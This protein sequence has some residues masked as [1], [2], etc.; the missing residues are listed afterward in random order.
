MSATSR[1]FR[2]AANGI[3]YL[4]TH[5]Y[6]FF[7]STQ[8]CRLQDSETP[9]DQTSLGAMSFEKMHSFIAPG[10][11]QT[12]S[13]PGYR[14]TKH[15][16]PSKFTYADLETY[17][18]RQ[19]AMRLDGIAPDDS[20]RYHVEVYIYCPPCACQLATALD[21]C[22]HRD[23]KGFVDFCVRVDHRLVTTC[24]ASSSRIEGLVSVVDY[25][26]SIETGNPLTDW[27]A[28]RLRA[29][30]REWLERQIYEFTEADRFETLS[31]A[32]QLARITSLHIGESSTAAII[33]LGE[34]DYSVPLMRAPPFP[35][36]ESGRLPR[37]NQIFRNWYKQISYHPSKRTWQREFMGTY[38]AQDP[39]PPKR[40]APIDS[41]TAETLGRAQ[42][43]SK[44]PRSSASVEEGS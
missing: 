29:I 5:G 14:I 1:A 3:V 6:I 8:S 24:S 42:H 33:M 4:N 19:D 41:S 15:I 18:E 30:D 9:C 31:P 32:S 44:R 7:I 43:G 12:R 22:L 26:R 20:R 13:A 17:A 37:E 35:P 40:P 23:K 34:A 11:V 21:I 25:I 2:T 16:D 10:S 27:T 38:S 28:E 36:F 39:L